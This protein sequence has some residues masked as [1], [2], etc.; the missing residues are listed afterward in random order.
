MG[1]DLVDICAK[2]ENENQINSYNWTTSLRR[3]CE[4]EKFCHKI[5]IEISILMKKVINPLPV[6][7]S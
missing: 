5:L 6:F 4:T 1:C 2:A 3:E 7:R